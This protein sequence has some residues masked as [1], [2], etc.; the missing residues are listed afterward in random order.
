[1]AEKKRT[2]IYVWVIMILIMGGLLGF[3][4]G[5]FSGSIQTIGSAGDKPIS[6]AA[7][8]AALNDQLRRF[9]AQAGSRVTFQQAQEIG[10]DR[11]VLGRIVTERT[12]DH[13]ATEMGLSVGDD[14]IRDEV[15]RNPAFQTLSGTF[16]R[17]AYRNALRNVGLSEE[18]YETALRDEIGRSLLQGAVVGGITA[19]PAFAE[20]IVSY[21]GETRDIVTAPVTAA[22]LTTPV[23]GPTEADLQT[24]Y[25]ENP[26]LFTA[27]ES[28]AISYVLLT[29]TMLADQITIDDAQVR[30]LYDE[31][32]STFSQPERRLVERL[33]FPDT[34]EA[35]AAIARLNANEVTFPA[36]V[37]ERGLTLSDVDLGDVAIDALAAAGDAVFAADTG[38]VVGPLDTSLGPALFRVNAILAAENTPFEDAEPALRD[39]L[40]TAQARRIIQTDSETVT[41]LMAG[42]ASLEDLTERTDLELG[43]L[44]Y[45]DGTT[46]GPAA[47]EAFRTAAATVAEGAFPTLMGLDD[48]GVFALRLDG[49]TP[50]SVIPMAEVRDR[51]EAAWRAAAAQTAVLTRAEAIAAEA[52][53]D[54]DLATL[55]LVTTSSA[56]LTRGS[57]VADTPAEFMATVFTMTEGEV[58]ALPTDTGAIVVRL[59]RISAADMTT[60]RLSAQLTDVTA[61]AAAGTAQDIFDAFADAVRART[62][63]VIDQAAIN[64]VNAQL[65]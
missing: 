48:G 17:E 18:E 8:Q 27:P 37:T 55:N 57:F 64:A 9:E 52:S 31:R 41:D 22:D 6:T 13:E 44:D 58:R 36:L 40:A 24:F 23:P 1:M 12:L 38:D 15:L 29:P 5:G 50:A 61:Q 7:Y 32:I 35:E 21:L 42:G 62:D 54:T 43:T 10:L 33:V 34:A 46:A 56:N 26:D 49:I 39:E 60:D 59:D 47:Y 16:D 30:S 20:T 3:G 53:A 45:T 4:T 2:P 28:R 11:A 51:L 25:D 63:V 14:L 65:Q 19:L